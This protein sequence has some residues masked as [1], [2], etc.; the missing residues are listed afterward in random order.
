MLKEH[1]KEYV[2]KENFNIFFGDEYFNEDY[3][4]EM[5]HEFDNILDE[6]ED[7]ED[8]LWNENYNPDYTTLKN[9]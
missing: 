9:N 1:L 5:L 7:D 6:G 2:D 3:P 4:Y 8:K